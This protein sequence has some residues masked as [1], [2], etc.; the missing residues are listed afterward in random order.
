MEHP[1]IS[2]HREALTCSAW[3]TI[4]DDFYFQFLDRFESAKWRNSNPNAGPKKWVAILHE[5]KKFRR[6]CKEAL[7]KWI[8]SQKGRELGINDRASAN[9]HAT[10]PFDIISNKEMYF[11][12]HYAPEGEEG[13]VEEGQVQ[14]LKSYDA[15][16][17]RDLSLKCS[18]KVHH[19][20]AFF[21]D[22]ERF[23]KE[24]FNLFERCSAA[25]FKISAAVHTLIHNSN[26]GG[27]EVEAPAVGEK[28]ERDETEPAFT[29]P[30][31]PTLN[32]VEPTEARNSVQSR[33][34][35]RIVVIGVQGGERLNETIHHS[36]RSGW[37][38]NSKMPFGSDVPVS[39]PEP[40]WHKMCELYKTFGEEVDAK[41]FSN[42]LNVD[43]QQHIRIPESAS[44][45]LKSG[46]IGAFTLLRCATLALRYESNLSSGSLQL[47]ADPALKEVFQA[48]GYHVV[49]LCASPINAFVTN[50]SATNV[51]CSAFFDIDYFFGSL[52]SATTLDLKELEKP[53]PGSWLEARLQSVNGASSKPLCLT[54]DVPYDED[55]CNLL[56]AKLKKDCCDANISSKMCFLLVLP[57]WWNIAFKHCSKQMVDGHNGAT[58]TTAME[59]GVSYLNKG[60]PVTYTWPEDLAESRWAEFDAIF[61]KDTYSYFCTVSNKFLD[62]VTATEVIGFGA[63]NK[64]EDGVPSPKQI[65]NKFYFP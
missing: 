11:L 19:D 8:L 43:V 28:R 31:H 63:P 12:P 10:N 14:N 17:I 42:Q 46:D 7:G 65:L 32:V 35:G 5:P 30:F 1:L 54:L 4:R 44:T 22:L 60:Y 34:Q 62:G 6:H 55:L 48:E 59:Q 37:K 26:G 58:A 20:N 29:F 33:I 53:H 64:S 3:S 24:D 36:E 47:C 13:I 27:V 49:D 45:S 38:V 16:L 2:F 41:N 15:Q 39:I 50:S 56:F 21:A 61:V 57:L 9:L 18:P 25:H 40:V 51:F 23:V 52:G